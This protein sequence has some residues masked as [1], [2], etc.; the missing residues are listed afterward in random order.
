MKKV[1]IIFVSCYLA[2][3]SF[4]QVSIGN[5]SAPDSNVILDL[6]NGNNKGL[7][8]TNT[9]NPPTEPV[10]NIVFNSTYNMLSLVDTSGK[11]NLL[12]PWNYDPNNDL[13]IFLKDGLNLGLGTSNPNAKLHI[14]GATTASKLGGGGFFKLG[15]NNQHIVMDNTKIISKSNGVTESDL[16]LQE[17]GHLKVGNHYTTNTSD[18]TSGLS[19]P[20]PSGGIIMWSGSSNNIPAGWKLCDGSDGTPNLSGRFVVGIGNNGE[21]SYLSNEMDG[22]DNISLSI[23]NLPSHNHTGNTGTEGS[24]EHIYKDRFYIEN[25]SAID[26]LHEMHSSWNMGPVTQDGG[27]WPQ[28]GDGMGT[29]GTDHDNS[30][31]LYTFGKTNSG[32]LSS[33]YKFSNGTT[34][35]NHSNSA[36]HSHSISSQGNG[37]P[38]SNKPKYFAL[39]FIMKK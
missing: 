29:N 7:L 11:V 14:I 9:T 15:G 36:D 17:E 1:F 38:F 37:T 35:N 30:S 34:L 19:G 8:L 3:N 31:Y 12:S 26:D 2:I 10:G 6:S 39:A 13:I 20:V 23:S 28:H 4:G 32:T 18:V 24:H 22:S 27:N 33:A 25:N 16:Q 5:P 21:T